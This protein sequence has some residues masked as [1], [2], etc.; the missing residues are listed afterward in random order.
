M[1]MAL[2]IIMTSLTAFFAVWWVYF[3]ILKIAKEKNIVDNPEARKLQKRPIPVM[4]GIAVF[5]GI[6]MGV[7]MGAVVSRQFG[8]TS[9][10][11]MIS[12]L[13]AMAMLYVGAMDDIVGLSPIV[14]IFIESLVILG[15]IYTGGMCIDSFHGLWNVYTFSWWIGVPLTVFACVGL[16]NSINMIDG[17]NGLSSGLCLVY[18]ASFGVA[19]I[20]SKDVAN[21]I[22]AF[23]M[24]GA[25]LPFIVHNVF[26]KHS[27]MFVGDAGTMSM[28]MVIAWFVISLLCEE[29]KVSAMS[30]GGD[31]NM[32]AMSLAILSVPVTDTLRVM[33][34]RMMNGKSPFE[35]DKTHLHHVFIKVGVSHII[36][37]F[38]E[39]MID[40]LV[41]LIWAI[42]VKLDATFNMQFYIVVVSSLALVVGTYLFLDYHLKHDTDFLERLNKITAKTHLGHRPWWLRFQRWLDGPEMKMF[43]EEREREYRIRKEEKFMFEETEK[44]E[45]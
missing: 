17:V 36:T 29:S 24:V 13:G 28:G 4:G 11:Y 32:V 18:C 20:V 26:G 1:K 5:F 16:I 40:A 42:S 33:V 15:L 12:V 41:V 8:D 22:L 3:K 35:P 6:V 2:T 45:K 38:S 31:Y 25:L 37:T 19:F 21:A 43:N 23:S 9:G 34:M 10:I 14:R 44:Q 39:I 30:K 7:I 27:R